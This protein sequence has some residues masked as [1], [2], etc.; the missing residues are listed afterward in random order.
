MVSLR[1]CRFL[2]SSLRRN[3]FLSGK[4]ECSNHSS[5]H[6]TQER[7]LAWQIHS[8]GGI[9]ELVLSNSVRIPA[10]T[11]PENILVKV[12]ASSVNPMDVAMMG[13]YGSTLL[14]IG[15]QLKSCSSDTLEFPL[16]LGRDFSGV[17]VEKGH[18]VND[19]FQFGD[20]VWGVVSPFQPGCHAQYTVVPMTNVMK[21]PSTLN[22]VEA[23]SV[24]YA[25]VT[26]WSA[27]KITGDLCL[28]SAHGKKVLVL[29]GSG[30]VGSAAVVC[31]CSGDAIPLV[32]SLGAD[33]VID[34]TDPNADIL[35][36]QE[37]KYDIILNAAG[38]RH[39][40]H[41]KAL[42]EQSLAKYITITSPLLRNA[43][44]HGIALGMA[45]SA[46][47]LISSNMNLRS[48]PFF[49]GG[50]SVRWGYFIPSSKAIEEITELAA[51]GLL[52]PAI[53]KVF[54]F[55]ELPAAYQK[56]LNGHS[57]DGQL[58]RLD[59]ILCKQ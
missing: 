46:F 54:P 12:S 15:R 44:Q 17:I 47:D 37:G 56:V 22:D 9:E 41:T 31:T 40:Q 18:G 13:G 33:A 39:P 30:G 1:Y 23:A 21:K 55:S 19:S 26:A 6:G 42:K 4:R 5:H 14:N 38:L 29:G 51:N 50:P 3:N 36:L 24:L 52:T 7:M 49:L 34:Y 48:A 8:Y 20:E 45:R 28:Q 10:I 43:D 16:I 53:E 58:Y 59:I 25:A 2:A 57:R 11:S 32:E 35:V 27:L